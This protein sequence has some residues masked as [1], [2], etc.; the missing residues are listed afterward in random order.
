MFGRDVDEMRQQQRTIGQNRRSN[1]MA[2][3]AALACKGQKCME[4]KPQMDTVMALAKSA[5]HHAL[6]PLEQEPA[7]RAYSL[8]HCR[9][10]WPPLAMGSGCPIA[11][12]RQQEAVS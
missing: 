8:L 6:Q 11:F 12:E 2:Y 5:C 1:T 3:Q 7:H 4:Q 10:G 9:Q